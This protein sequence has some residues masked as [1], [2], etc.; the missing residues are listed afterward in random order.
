MSSNK[1]FNTRVQMKHDV[2]ANW[3][4]AQ[5]F[6]PLAGEIIIYDADANTSYVRMKIGDG[7]TL[8]NDLPFT[9][10]YSL[11]TVNDIDTICGT[12]IQVADL[13]EGAF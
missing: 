10:D 7:A 8:V 4:L 5:N 9:D 13:N 11:I 3:K 1:T 2:E 6:V 12:S